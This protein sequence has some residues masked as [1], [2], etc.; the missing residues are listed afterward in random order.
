MTMNN[1]DRQNQILNEV[2]RGRLKNALGIVALR[3]T[4]VGVE[5]AR[6]LVL[7]AARNGKAQ[8]KAAAAIGRVGGEYDRQ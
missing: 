8:R 6:R 2:F 5:E 4:G 1:L 7:E 3:D